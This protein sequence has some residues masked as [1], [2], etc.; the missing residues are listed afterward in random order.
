LLGKP[1]DDAIQ[2][3]PSLQRDP[4]F[5]Y[6]EVGASREVGAPPGYYAVDRY[7]VK[8]GEGAEAYR[9]AVEALRG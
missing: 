9:R 3:F 6:K 7:Q 8:L 4:P 1:S 2:Q 5:S